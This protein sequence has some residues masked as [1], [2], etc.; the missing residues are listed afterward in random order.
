MFTAS[1]YIVEKKEGDNHKGGTATK[2]SDQTFFTLVLKMKEFLL[3][4]DVR[5]S[6]RKLL[7]AEKDFEGE[8]KK[9]QDKC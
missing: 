9:T 8:K 5:S 3:Q 1:L 7:E 2:L 6:W 4:Q